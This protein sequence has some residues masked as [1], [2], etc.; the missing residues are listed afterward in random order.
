MN[1]LAAGTYQFTVQASDLAGNFSAV[2]S[3]YQVVI[4][5]A[6]PAASTIAGVSETTNNGQQTLLLK[7]QAPANTQVIVSLAGSAIWTGTANS[8]GNWSFNYNSPSSNGQFANGS[9][10]FTAQADDVAP[11]PPC[12]SCCSATAC[13]TCPR[14]S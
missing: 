7:G 9:Y 8:Q 14:P 5:T 11:P 4:D 12:S 1:T 2:S 6:A 3:A 13:R 10:P